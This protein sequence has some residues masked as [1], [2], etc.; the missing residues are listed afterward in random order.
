[1]TNHVAVCGS[2]NMDLVCTAPRIPKPGET[3]L[4]YEF[5][6]KE[7]GKG[8]NQAV[9]LGRLG[10]P[11]LMIGCVGSDAFGEALL[12]SLKNSGVDT[13]MIKKLDGATGTAHITVEDSGENNIVVIPSANARVSVS[14]V[15][16]AEKALDG[17]FAAI[18]QLEIP[19]DAV[20]EFM[21]LS[22]ARETMCVLNPA[23]MPREG[24]SPDLL[25]LLDLITPNETELFQLTGVEP[26]DEASFG[27]AARILHEKGVGRVICTVGASGA[28]YSDGVTILHQNAMRVK[29][30]DTTCAG[31]SFTAA[32]VAK[33]RDGAPIEETLEF[34]TRAA[35]I[36]V[37]KLGA[38][39]SLPTREAIMSAAF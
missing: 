8:A 21:R 7:G 34:A 1:M 35:A 29:A 11:T 32:F 16:E 20:M 39:E 26:N 27:V 12:R 37:T 19:M 5:I 6:T 30:V 38:Q 22:K 28:Y 9:A 15:R 31:D 17:A 33:L 25:S 14:M 10:L 4:G 24:L 18:A 13:S 3:I 2:L 23:P 36:T